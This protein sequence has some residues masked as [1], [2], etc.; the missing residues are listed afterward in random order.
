MPFMKTI[1]LTT[2]LIFLTANLFAQK[3]DE[4]VIELLKKKHSLTE[5]DSPDK[6]IRFNK[7]TILIAGFLEDL[8]SNIP[9]YEQNTN[10]VYKT[11]DGG[12]N[13]KVTKFDGNAWIYISTNFSNGKVWMGG[14][15]NFIHYSDNYGETW[16]KFNP[17]F[18]PVNRVFSIYMVDENNGIAGGLSNG[19]AITTDNWKTTKQ[20]PTPIDQ[21]KFKI[22]PNSARNRIDKIRI[23]DSLI[24][25]S[26]NDYIYYSKLNPISWKEFKVP[27]LNFEIEKEKKIIDIHSRDGKHFILNLSLELI[28][29]YVENNITFFS[30]P[31]IGNVSNLKPFFDN[32]IK[33][34]SIQSKTY[35]PNKRVHMIVTYKENIESAEINLKNNEYIFNSKNY[36]KNTTDFNPLSFQHIIL[37]E[38]IKS[39]NQLKNKFKFDKKDFDDYERYLKIQFD[40]FNERENW[41]GNFTGMI[42]PS[43]VSKYTQTN[44]TEVCNSIDFEYIYTKN[45]FSETQNNIE[46]NFYNSKSEELKIS[47]YGSTIFSLPWKITYQNKIYHSYNPEITYL[48]RNIIPSN[49]SNYD[50]LLG[51]NLIYKIIEQDIT[52]KIEYE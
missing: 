20:I 44:I 41:G 52:N 37:S 33:R 31:E 14:S 7:D 32:Q 6:I 23:I 21:N 51:G 10:I 43:E 26:Q 30:L 24:L 49:F 25:I 45:F 1:R 19:L 11:T 12:K 28:E 13:W 15:D 35:E 40:E 16:T 38:S 29:K 2:L 36:K 39:L 8:T 9:R 46:I 50:M 4:E 18:N 3:T 22:L 17:P 27:V 34:I 42:K 47:N 5:Y 48:L